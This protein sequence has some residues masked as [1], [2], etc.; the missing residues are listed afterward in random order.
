MKF[1]DWLK[2]RD[3]K[4]QEFDINVTKSLKALGVAG[5]LGTVANHHTNFFT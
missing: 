4:F 3:E 2:N 5:V 1:E